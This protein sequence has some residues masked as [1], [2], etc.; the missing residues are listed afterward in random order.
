[1]TVPVSWAGKRVDFAATD[2]DMINRMSLGV[3]GAPQP[4]S[5]EQLVRWVDGLRVGGYLYVVALRHGV[6]MRSEVD[7]L[8]FL[9]PSAA[10]LISRD[11]TRELNY[12]GMAWEKRVAR[13]GT[14]AGLATTSLQVLR[15]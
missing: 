5:L 10:M 13:P 1:M 9:P 12:Q 4:E 14:V 15:Y 8:P 7:V 11:A 2:A 3:G 6:G